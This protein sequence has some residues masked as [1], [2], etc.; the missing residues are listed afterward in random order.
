MIAFGGTPDGS[1]GTDNLWALDISD[2]DVSAANWERLDADGTGPSV[3]VHVAA[4]DRGRNW[5]VVYGGIRNNYA[6]PGRE[7]SETRTWILDLNEEPPVW[8][9]LGISLGD[10]I[11]AVAGFVD[12]FG[13]VVVASGRERVADPIQSDFNVRTIHGLVCPEAPTA[14][15]VAT[16]TSSPV[17][18]ETATSPPS[19][20]ATAAAS[21]TVAPTVAP[22]PELRYLPALRNWNRRPARAA[23]VGRDTT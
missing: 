23:G 14:T 10:R 11:Q 22:I 8:R 9:N 18:T 19:P 7:S 20:T 1:R 13:A 6:I 5:M 3:A 4:Y 15:P 12:K 21:A 17:P 16:V 2:P